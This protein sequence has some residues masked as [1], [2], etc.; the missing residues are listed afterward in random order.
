MSL[1]ICLNGLVG[2][3]LSNTGFFL[4]YLFSGLDDTS[5]ESGFNPSMFF[6]DFIVVPPSR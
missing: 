1:Y 4:N 6:L 3:F 2:Y 5:V